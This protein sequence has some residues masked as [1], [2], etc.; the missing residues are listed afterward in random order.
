[1]WTLAAAPET[2]FDYLQL[3]V[4]GI[5]LVAMVTGWIWAR[6]AV[7]QLIADLARERRLREEESQRWEKHIMP[8]LQQFDDKVEMLMNE[9]S[10]R[11]RH[12][13]D[14]DVLLNAVLEELRRRR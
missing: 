13:R 2:P 9:L 6:P 11:N 12:D 10:E 4:V 3:G 1:M 7:E 5:V 14:R 8:L